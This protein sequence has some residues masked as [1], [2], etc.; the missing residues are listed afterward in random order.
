MTMAM[1]LGDGWTVT[2]RNLFAMSRNPE[3]VIWSTIQPVMFIVLFVYVFDSIPTPGMDYVDYVM[4]G[5]FV[6]TVMFNSALTGVGLATD[7]QKG[8]IDRFRSLPMAR[9][10]VLVGRTTGDI[11]NGLAQLVVMVLVGTIVGW[12]TDA[13]VPSVIAG[14]L[15][16][17]V[18]GY[19]FSWISATV[20]LSVKSVEVANS[21]GFVWMF[22]VTFVSSTFVDINT[23]SG[24]VRTIAEWN[25]MSAFVAA[26]RELF[27]N[28]SEEMPQ[29][30]VWPLQNPILASV[31]WLLLILAIFVP[32]SVRQYKKA[33]S[34]SP[35]WSWAERWSVERG[36]QLRR[37]GGA[38]PEPV[39]AL[40]QQ[41]SRRRGEGTVGGEGEATAHRHAGDADLGELGDRRHAGEHEDV[42]RHVD[43]LD[44]AGDLLGGGDR[45]GV[46]D[47]GA[48][49]GVGLQPG[50]RVVE[51]VDAAEVVLGAT[52][53]H[54][55][56]RP[57]MGR[58]GSG[59]NPLAG[60]PDVVDRL[61][62]RVPVL[63]R[64]AGETGSGGEG[65][66]L[67][68]VGGARGEAVLE[69]GAHRQRR[70][71]GELGA[72]GDRLVAG[73]AAVVA[74]ERVGESGTRRGQRGVAEVGE[75][76]GA[77]GVPGVGH[78]QRCAGSM[79]LGEADGPLGSGGEV[80][81]VA[82]VDMIHQRY[83]VRVGFSE[84]RFRPIGTGP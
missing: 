47:V 57:G 70:R 79:Q 54:E 43:G 17:L 82:I 34:L 77:A 73:H 65:D 62:V 71:R 33:A 11:V 60:E 26:V 35:S 8:I 9:S 24:A 29:P 76:L 15:L 40:L 75:D 25:P 7:I 42:D 20:G 21:A 83:H 41:L 45:R 37:R 14:L 10:A 64:A 48:G 27:G 81:R 59:G 1:T 16:V 51:V 22:P 63:D 3:V 66:C 19:V 6:Q 28:T 38:F 80:G 5:I 2:R 49:G 50:D 32:L 36:A 4:A 58:L 12:R 56:H 84:D 44:D 69:V 74:A 30:D 52:R 39:G 23:L 13:S 78:Q 55:T 72:V 68:D 61:L 31:L 18:I 53:E 67:G 46:D